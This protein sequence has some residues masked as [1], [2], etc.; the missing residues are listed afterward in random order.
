MAWTECTKGLV[1]D[2]IIITLSEIGQEIHRLKQNRPFIR[3]LCLTSLAIIA[4]SLSAAEIYAH[5]YTVAKQEKCNQ[6]FKA[7][8]AG[9]VVKTHQALTR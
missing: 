8:S 2:D 7:M 9:V 3:N 4:C 5:P 1:K 6:L